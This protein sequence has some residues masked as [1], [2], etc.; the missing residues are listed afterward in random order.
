MSIVDVARRAGV[1][2][3]TVSRVINH[4]PGVSAETEALIRAVM[5]ELGYVPPVPERRRGPK[6]SRVGCLGKGLAVLLLSPRYDETFEG[7]YL[8]SQIEA[9]LQEGAA[10]HGATLCVSSL[11]QPAD[12]ASFGH[13]GPVRALFVLDGQI[14]DSALAG[15]A[16]IPVVHLMTP[17][18]NRARP[19]DVVCPD[20]AAV[21]RQAAEYLM[22]RGHERLCVIN[23]VSCWAAAA[24]RASAFVASACLAGRDVNLLG[25][26]RCEMGWE[27]DSSIDCHDHRIAVCEA[28]GRAFLALAP[29]PTGLFVTSDTIAAI[30]Y[31]ILSH[32][33]VVIGRDVEVVSCNNDQD[34]LGPLLP[35]PPTFDLQGYEIGRQAVDV[36]AA[37]VGGTLRLPYVRI[38]VA[39]VP[40]LPS[41]T[42]S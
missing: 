36:A 34:A 26:T 27:E 12:A 5:H 33:G 15:F 37:R 11:S 21:G 38:E 6:Q 3:S 7:A 2:V 4:Q 22:S 23:P 35:R 32:A 30:I 8:L 42:A 13:A 25:G 10:E 28:V 14:P 9:G 40:V 31:R 16:G 24:E 29:R 41:R 20:S 18:L 1:S 19:W 39:P 17:S